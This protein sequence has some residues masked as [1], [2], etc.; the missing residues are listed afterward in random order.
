[1]IGQFSPNI[2]WCTGILGSS[3][4]FIDHTVEEYIL[5]LYNKDISYSEGLHTASI[6]KIYHTLMEYILLL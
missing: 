5:L 2:R 6:T 1:V 3:Q 4:K